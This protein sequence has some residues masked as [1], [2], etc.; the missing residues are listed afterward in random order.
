MLHVLFLRKRIWT[1]SFDTTGHCRKSLTGHCRGCLNLSED[2]R[3][4]RRQKALGFK[5]PSNPESNSGDWY[6]ARQYIVL[7]YKFFRSLSR[8]K[9]SILRIEAKKSF[10][11]SSRGKESDQQSAVGKATSNRIL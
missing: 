4:P 7:R 8:R 11:M 10:V 2:D 9:R 1:R 3:R 6:S 5:R